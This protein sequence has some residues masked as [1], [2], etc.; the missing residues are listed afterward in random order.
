MSVYII[1]EKVTFHICKYGDM[2]IPYTLKN[3]FTYP[4]LKYN[5]QMISI[6]NW[7]IL[8][9]TYISEKIIDKNSWIS[10]YIIYFY[11][12]D[13]VDCWKYMTQIKIISKI[14][15]ILN[16]MMFI[17][18]KEIYSIIP[19]KYSD[20]TFFLLLLFFFWLLFCV[21]EKSWKIGLYYSYVCSMILICLITPLFFQL[22]SSFCLIFISS[23]EFN[24]VLLY[25]NFNMQWYCTWFS[26]R[27]CIKLHENYMIT[28]AEPNT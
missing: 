3:F 1:S 23:P 13:L 11:F 15:W 5:F 7:F 21:Y 8:L 26:H 20:K 4:F 9:R 28:E 14:R 24:C 22:A 2:D 17:A 18:Q 27:E 25:W 10:N 6:I 19:L 16:I 12:Q